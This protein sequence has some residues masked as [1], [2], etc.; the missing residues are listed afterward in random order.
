MLKDPPILTIRRNFKRPAPELVAKLA[1]AQTGHIVD[2]LQGRGALDHHVKPVDPER[3]VFVGPALTCECGANDNLAIMAALVVAEPGH[4]IIAACDGFAATA[5][6]GDNLAMMA[7]NKGV[8]AVVTDGMARD[9]EGIVAAGLPVFARGIT[10]N[11]CVRSGPGRLGFAVVCGGVAVEAGDVVVGDRDGVVVIPHAQ[12]EG[13]VAA[14]AEIRRM[15]EATQAKIRAGMT[16]LD[17][18]AELLR[19]DRVAHVD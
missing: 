5:V 3:A 19:S 4:V 15:E 13:V 17:S 11:S 7:K 14:L 12:L 9:R 8:A 16:H 10:P 6:V 1:G 2:A 18:V